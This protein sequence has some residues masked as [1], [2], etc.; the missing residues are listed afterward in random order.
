EA[1]IVFT[2]K[3]S[4]DKA[5]SLSGTSFFSRT[6]TVWSCCYLNYATMVVF[7]K[8]AHLGTRVRCDKA[9]APRKISG[10]GVLMKRRSGTRMSPVAR[11]LERAPNNN[12]RSNDK[13][14]DYPVILV[15]CCLY[16]VMRKADMSPGS[17]TPTLPSMKLPQPRYPESY[18][19][20]PVQRHYTKSHLQWRRDESATDTFVSVP[21]NKMESSS[22]AK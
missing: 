19:K 12:K 1:Y 16:Q 10:R 2:N 21:T 3:W 6:L 15:R 17:L 5:I 11:C 13:L 8:G 4:V 9:Q 22:A 20:V 18:K 14:L 7:S